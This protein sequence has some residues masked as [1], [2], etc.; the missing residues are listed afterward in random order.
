MPSAPDA[1][2]AVRSKPSN[3]SRTRKE[4]IEYTF[5]S[6]RIK[7]IHTRLTITGAY[8][9]TVNSNSQPLWYKPSVIVAGKE[10]QYAGL[11][12]DNDG[13]IYRSFNTN[14][15][16]D[17]DL[18]R[19]GLNFS[20]GIQNIWFTSRQ[21]LWRDGRP[22]QYIDIDGNIRPY[23]DASADDAYLKQLI[24]PYSENS[25]VRL[26]VPVETTVNLKATKTFWKKR[27]GMAVY[28]NRLI[29]IQPD[30][31][32]YGITMRRYS[33]PYFGMELNLKF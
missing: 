10:L 8:F 32:R 20:I 31:K 1:Y 19:L 29:A 13:N 16:F 3:G 11:Y 27:I 2:L 7:S 6:R 5:R 12:D 15:L 17:T 9:R 33:T 14:F 30:Y 4:G 18:P 23:T 22:V 26:T 24:R 28:V 25:F 21:T